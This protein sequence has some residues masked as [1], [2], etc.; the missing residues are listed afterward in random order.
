MTDI[1]FNDDNARSFV[2]GQEI[3][4]LQADVDRLH[5]D[6]EKGAGQGS[7][8]LGWLHLPSRTSP[9]LLD[10]IISTQKEITDQC[11]AFVCVGI[12]GSYLGARAAISFLNPAF[13]NPHGPEIYFAGQNISSDYHADL[14]DRLADR[15]VCINVISK[16]GTTTEPA[17]AFRLLSNFMEKKYGKEESRKRIVVT[18]DSQKGALKTL[19]DEEG[20]KSFV[21]PDD[22]GGRFSVLT[23]VG[24]LP[25]AMTG[26]DI[27]ALLEGA[28]QSENALTQT[29]D[30]SKNMA[31][32][33]AAN[34]HLL[35]QKGKVIE[36]MATF[37]PAFEYILEWWKQLAG[38][39]EGKKGQGIFP[40]SAQYTTDLHSLG[41]W[42][43]D[44]NRNLFETFLLVEKSAHSIE[45]PS[46]T[47]DK[48]GLG[49]LEGKSL[50][51]VNEKAYKG[52][53]A[54]HLEGG[55][56]SLILALKERSAYNLGQLIYFFERAVAMTGYLSEV[57]PF[58]Q[59]G[60]EFYKKNMFTLLNKPGYEKGK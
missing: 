7:D 38:E 1:D 53:A 57:N 23:P 47:G 33:Y 17:I 12:G 34:R 41:Q 31:Y 44:G 2:S 22:V 60:V 11:D 58:D 55:V 24:L 16:S 35:Y 30:L 8:Y 37:H 40:A 26:I 39:S 20:Y 48:D 43:Q 27:R 32:R 4:S 36:L 15:E 59:P 14:L 19:A 9:S 51:F 18:T 42:V 29:S 3:D 25:I 13:G 46:V 54:A 21:I 5:D 50:D 10:S 49:Y 52:S 28:V 45:I 56:P 6:L